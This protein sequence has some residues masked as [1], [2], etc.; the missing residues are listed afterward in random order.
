MECLG[1]RANRKVRDIPVATTAPADVKKWL[2]GYADA[3][4]TTV[5]LT[6]TELLEAGWNLSALTRLARAMRTR[7]LLER[8]I[9]TVYAQVPH[10]PYGPAKVKSFTMGPPLAYAPPRARI[11]SFTM[12]DPIGGRHDAHAA[13]RAGSPS[14]PAP[15]NARIGSFTMGEPVGMDGKNR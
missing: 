8:V 13:P 10:V 11:A 5:V 12:G 7:G 15:S 2:P 14:A 4:A 3:L 9:E 1:R 6:M